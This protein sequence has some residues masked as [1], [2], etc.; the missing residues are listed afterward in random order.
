MWLR[1]PNH[2]LNKRPLLVQPV[3]PGAAATD[4]CCP[5][6]GHHHPSLQTQPSYACLVFGNVT[7]V[8][9]AFDI[10]TSA[11]CSHTHLISAAADK[12]CS[13]LSPI[14]FALSGECMRNGLGVLFLPGGLGSHDLT[15]LLE[16]KT[17]WREQ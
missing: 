14:C 8:V 15:C 3:P 5:I 7:H 10:R 11:V 9:E 16:N 13:L 17:L 1:F 6:P 2:P 12:S 4:S